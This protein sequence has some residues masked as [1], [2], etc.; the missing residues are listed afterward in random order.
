MIEINITP[1]IKQTNIPL[2]FFVTKVSNHA[3]VKKEILE[4]IDS[5]GIYS[6]KN[7]GQEISNTDWHLSSEFN[8]PYIDIARPI[9]SNHMN[10]LKEHFGYDVIILENYWFQQYKKGDFHGEHTHNGC[11]F[12]SVY[13]VSLDSKNPKTTFK[14]LGK[15]Y[16]FDIEEGSIISFPSFLVHSSPPNET[17]HIKTVISFNLNAITE[18]SKIHAK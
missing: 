11:T 1:E 9:I 17:D 4:A 18:P 13:Y 8:R 3:S 6:F 14:Y 16:S 12:S 15:D 2:N 7:D 10:L 5:Q